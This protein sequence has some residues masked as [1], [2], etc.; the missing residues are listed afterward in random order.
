MTRDRLTASPHPRMEE[1]VSSKAAA[2]LVDLHSKF[3]SS[4]REVLADRRI[5]D[6]RI[7]DG[8]Q[9]TFR[10]ETAHIRNGEWGVAPPPDDLRDRRTEI[11]G[12]VSRPFMIE[13]LMY[14]K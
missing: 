1:I 2:F 12:P 3:E 10:P 11:T 7:R 5:R 14:L 8:A 13:A 4:R 6:Q 9:P